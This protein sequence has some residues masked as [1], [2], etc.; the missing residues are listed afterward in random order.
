MPPPPSTGVKGVRE[1][2]FVKKA[3]ETSRVAVTAALTVRVKVLLAVDPLLSVTVTVYVVAAVVTFGVPLIA[4]VLEFK[5]KPPGRLGETLY[6]SVPV[7]FAPV[8][9][10]KLVAIWFCV[11]MMEDTACVAVTAA[12]MVRLKVLDAVALF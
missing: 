2:F 4:P 5:L 11:R 6:V 12:L 10:I 8:T 7:P 3:L 9:G 1:K